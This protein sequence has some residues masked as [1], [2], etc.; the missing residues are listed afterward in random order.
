MTRNGAGRSS[1]RTPGADIGA[2]EVQVRAALPTAEAAL[3]I[4]VARSTLKK[5]RVIG[6]G[7]SYVKVGSKVVY[8]VADLEDFLRDRR[9]E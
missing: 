2:S 5:W 6:E 8:M 3:Y 7:P 9:V 4:G 1:G